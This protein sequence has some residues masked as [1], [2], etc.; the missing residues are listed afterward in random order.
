[1]SSA[2]RGRAGG[3]RFSMFAASEGKSRSF[4]SLQFISIR[5]EASCDCLTNLKGQT[6]AGSQKEANVSK[7]V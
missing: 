1:M 4:K 2:S 5:E 7:C 6:R 3:G